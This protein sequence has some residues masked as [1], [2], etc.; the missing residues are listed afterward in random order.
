[1]RVLFINSVCG[2]R[3]T[4]RICTDLAA[5]LKAQGH[6]VK[7]AFGRETVPEQ[8]RRQA[9]RIGTDLDVKLHGL[10]S[11][12]LDEH[13]LGS[14]HATKQFLEWA[15]TYD[16]DLLWLHNI[17]GYY[18]N[19][20]LLFSWIKKRPKMEVRWTL[21]DSWAFTGHCAGFSFIGCEQWKTHCQ[22]CPLKR[23]YPTSLWIDRCSQSYDKKK[24]AFSGVKNMTLITP[25]K[26]LADLVGQS[27]LCEYPVEVHHNTIDTSIFRPTPSNFREKH[28][29]TNVK[30]ALGVASAWGERK[31]LYDFYKL[32]T[33]LD[34]NWRVVLVGLNEK[35]IKE[36][37]KG[38][39]GIERTNSPKELAE[40]YTTADVFL[41]PTYSDNYPTV[42]LEAEA[43]GTRVVTYDTGGCRE[44]IKRG[45][46][47]VVPVGDIQSMKEAC[48]K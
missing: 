47:C 36:L 16:P 30:I 18:I 19:Y 20:E 28:G 17:H 38:I 21:H 33:M 31:G 25:S 45:D 39:I 23:G 42:I 43:C 4:G 8:F 26:W 7:I 13:G 48:C 9:V 10:H 14:C 11:R 1:M 24:T 12:L 22:T 37:P 35:Q 44:G 32:S 6:E 41:D 3:S 2:I 34:E 5:E 29:L 46:S 40:I 27:F 15:D